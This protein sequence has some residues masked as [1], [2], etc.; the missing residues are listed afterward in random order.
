[1]SSGFRSDTKRGIVECL[2]VRNV[3]ARGLH[4]AVRGLAD[5]DRD[6]G[7]NIPC[8]AIMILMGVRDQEAEQAVVGFPEP[9]NRRQ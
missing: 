6:V 5:P 3:R 9:R 7:A 8:E 4:D 1:M 2:P